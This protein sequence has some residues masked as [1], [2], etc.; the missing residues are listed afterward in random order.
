MKDFPEFMKSK[1]TISAVRSKILKMLMATFMKGQ[2]VV[3]W[4]FGPA[5]LTESQKSIPM[6]LMST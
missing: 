5:I 4:H 1:K 3:K 2:M 6:N